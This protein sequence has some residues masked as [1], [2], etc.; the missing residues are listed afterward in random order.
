MRS[1][2]IW[3]LVPL[4]AALA[5]GGWG[6]AR[7]KWYGLIPAVV[8]GLLAF[9]AG[10]FCKLYL[11][12]YLDPNVPSRPAERILV[13]LLASAATLVSLTSIWAG[14]SRGHWFW[15]LSALAGIPA[16]LASIDAKEP[17]LFCLATM[18]AIAGGAWLIRS[19]QDRRRELDEVGAGEPGNRR[20]RWRWSLRDALLVFVIVGL[21]AVTLRPLIVGD[22]YFV[23][24]KF[25]ISSVTFIAVSL[26]ATG[27][28]VARLPG[29]RWLFSLVTLVV[30]IS[31]FVVHRFLVCDA[32]GLLYYF[33]LDSRGPAPFISLLALGAAVMTTALVLLSRLYVVVLC[34]K[35]L[36][37]KR[38]ASG[39]LGVA[40]L[41]L[42]APLALVY[43][44]M[45]PSTTKVTPLPPSVTYDRILLAG[46]KAAAG[47]YTVGFKAAPVVKEA[48]A[49]LA[50]PGNVWFSRRE[51]RENEL[52]WEYHRSFH[53]ESML[54]IMLEKETVKAEQAGR[55]SECLELA[56]LQWRL[57][58]VL[59]RGG[60]YMDWAQGYRAEAYGC[61]AVSHAADKLSDDECRRALAEVRQS[62][63]DRPDVGTVLAYNT[64][65]KGAC[66][67]WREDL[68]RSARWLAGENPNPI[69]AWED[70]RQLQNLDQRG[71]LRLQLMET[72]LA[73][74]VFRREHGHWPP[75][76]RD[77]VPKYLPAMP[78]DPYSAAPLIYRPQDE[79]FLLYSVGPDGG[80]NGG[81]LSSYEYDMKLKGFDIDWDMDHR[82]QVN[83]WPRQEKP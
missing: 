78:L 35:S 7:W 70:T 4:A 53:W 69:H 52:S 64:Y 23:G 55:S 81:R 40:A 83:S 26:V 38:L 76:L 1:L 21:L 30:M 68:D 66:F 79:S 39:V 41:A 32:L 63:E 42:I 71:L 82:I 14:Y 62:L 11:Q 22:L 60:V 9:A 57:G 25:L 43:P 51:F 45:F 34:S 13:W 27:A 28:G 37:R 80:D 6:V 44:R 19:R 59:R 33:D 36:V 12:E 58:R 74:E 2:D 16:L 75:G 73:L 50:E 54:C 29:R 47:L 65:W 56:I 72:R 15:R 5:T 61:G 31:G 48:K 17:I 67:G 20:A 46:Q 77:L 3:L 24:Q 18:P 49:A 10:P 8:L